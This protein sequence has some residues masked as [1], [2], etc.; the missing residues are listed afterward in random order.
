M[1]YALMDGGFMDFE[2]IPKRHRTLF[3]T[4]ILLL[5]LLSI[6]YINASQSRNYPFNV[7]SAWQCN[8]P[9]FSITYDTSENGMLISYAVL[10]WNNE[11]VP[12]E[13][14]FL[15]REYDV[16]PAGSSAYSDRLFSGTWEYRNGNFVLV[17]IEDFIFDYKYSELVFSPVT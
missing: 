9:Y 14:C 4:L 17:I 7:E 5:G 15:M 3:V 13:L 8:D 2:L 16:Y 6:L 12:V 10:A 11:I 1:K